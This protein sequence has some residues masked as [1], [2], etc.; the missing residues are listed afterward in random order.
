MTHQWSDDMVD[1]LILLVCS[2]IIITTLIS[3]CVKETDR[4]IDSTSRA[5]NWT[6]PAPTPSSPAT[7]TAKPRLSSRCKFT[8]TVS[9]FPSFHSHVPGWQIVRCSRSSLVIPVRDPGRDDMLRTNWLRSGRKLFHSLMDWEV[10]RKKKKRPIRRV[11]SQKQLVLACSTFDFVLAACKWAKTITII[12]AV[13][14]ET[15]SCIS[16]WTSLS[17]K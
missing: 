13:S 3:S 15:N 8:R 11:A 5:S 16:V 14:A 12:H 17:H 1:W 10:D 2:R 6:L 4:C 7:F 9:L